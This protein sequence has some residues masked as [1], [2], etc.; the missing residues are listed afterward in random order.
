MGYARVLALISR[1]L[2]VGGMTFGSSVPRHESEG[3]M[4]EVDDDA[5]A[6][7]G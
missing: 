1:M 6:M 5:E 3:L 7:V 4:K 2:F